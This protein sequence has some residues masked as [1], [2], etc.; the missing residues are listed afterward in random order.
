[1]KRLNLIQVSY[2]NIEGGYEGEGNIDTDPLLMLRL[3]LL[4]R[5]LICIRLRGYNDPD[6]TISI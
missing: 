2:S 4:S 5:R 3:W 1:M 6:G